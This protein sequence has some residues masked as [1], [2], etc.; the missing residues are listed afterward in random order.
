MRNNNFIQMPK[1]KYMRVICKK[2]KSDQ[3]IY[4]KVATVVKCN[5]CGEILAEPTGGEASILGKV[6]E[7]IG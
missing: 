2:C 4:N 1:S 6:V 3:M 7:V 5:K